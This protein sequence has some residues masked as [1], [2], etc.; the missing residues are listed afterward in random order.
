MSSAGTSFSCSSAVLRLHKHLQQQTG[1][2]E[3]SRM[4]QDSTGGGTDGASVEPAGVTKLQI[5]FHLDLRP[6]ESSGLLSFSAL[7]SIKMTSVHQQIPF[8]RPM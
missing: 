1:W 3:S 7:T 5:H 6:A 4:S 2:R 8:E